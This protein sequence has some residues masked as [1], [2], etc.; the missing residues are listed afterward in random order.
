[1]INFINT[2]LDN[3]RDDEKD[4]HNYIK[5][6]NVIIVGPSPWMSGK[7]YGKMIDEFDIVVR[8]NQGIFLPNDNNEDFGT[9]TDI[10]YTSQR[11]RDEYG[12]NLPKE[13]SDVKY[14]AILTQKK[15]KRFPAVECMICHNKLE[16]GDEYC[17]NTDWKT[18]EKKSICHMSCARPEL[19][20]KGYNV[21]KRDVSIYDLFY[22]S[23]MLSGMLAVIDMLQFQAKTINIIGFDF[24]DSIKTM[25]E[26]KE[27]QI[28][29]SAIYSGEY[30]VFADTMKLSH[31]DE[32]GK[33][34]FLLKTLMREYKNIFIDDNLKEIMARR[35]KYTVRNPYVSEITEFIKDKKVAIVGCSAEMNENLGE[36]IDSHDIVVRVN[37]GFKLSKTKLENV[38]KKTDIVFINQLIRK[39]YGLEFS[40]SFDGI[41][42]IC[43]VVI[44]SQNTLC[45]VCGEKINGEAFITES[46]ASAK[47]SETEIKKF[48][49]LKYA[50]WECMC[51][52]NYNLCSQKI[53]L[54]DATPFFEYVQEIPLTG[55]IALNYVLNCKPN[56]ISLYGF[57]FFNALKQ[58]NKNISLSELYIGNYGMI[59]EPTI[60]QKDIFSKQLVLFSKIYKKYKDT[61]LITKKLKQILSEKNLL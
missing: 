38:G 53:I 32:D 54:V 37:M 49:L 35:L 40:P 20:Y 6:K 57:D 19:T 26:N 13:F 25:L 44:K 16:N 61:I 9:R 46:I 2:Y 4:Y 24:Y 42:Y 31:K 39:E 52:T 33:Q 36:E 47:I 15:H 58:I 1:M 30:K 11:A 50:H 48:P 14:I 34:L 43:V 21:V 23:A 10:I 3:L 51:Y 56:S 55:L 27:T 22:R 17:L 45:H 60:A 59:D 12:T 7:K 5:D 28:K 18:S 29:G 41:K 8:V